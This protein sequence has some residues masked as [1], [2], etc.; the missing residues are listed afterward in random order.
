MKNYRMNKVSNLFLYCFAI[1]LGLVVIVCALTKSNRIE[2]VASVASVS[3]VLF[4]IADL[5]AN[6]KNDSEKIN[7]M[8]VKTSEKSAELRSLRRVRI[9]NMKQYCQVKY[10]EY[11]TTSKI[12]S[13]VQEPIVSVFKKALEYIS[14]IDDAL[15]NIQRE[16]A[17]KAEGFPKNFF[18]R[19]NRNRLMRIGVAHDLFLI[20]GFTSIL[21]MLVFY[22]SLN[23]PPSLLNHFTVVGFGIIMFIYASRDRA[24]EQINTAEN[25]LDEHIEGIK[26]SIEFEQK[27]MR[28]MDTALYKNEASTPQ[29]A[30]IQL[31]IYISDFVNA[32]KV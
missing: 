32:E 20:V 29:E 19:Y 17:K 4:T 7:S 11:S 26:E 18:C 9:G 21:C 10:E 23:L 27:L 15:E 5:Y 28:W 1:F 12:N 2:M 30:E 13:K 24:E 8:L 14:S 22:E 31:L 3:G 6:N 25:I 16:D